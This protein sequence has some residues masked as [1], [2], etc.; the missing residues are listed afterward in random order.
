MS[1]LSGLSDQ[2]LLALAQNQG[3][4]VPPQPVQV[5]AL[6]PL[7]G[8]KVNSGYDSGF[9]L[10]HLS[11]EQLQG[12][13]ANANPQMSAGEDIGRSVV[14]GFEKA[15][16]GALGAVGNLENLW[17]QGV[18]WAGH[19]AISGLQNFTGSTLGAPDMRN[20]Q[21][22]PG[23][24]DYAHFNGHPT[25]ADYDAALQSKLG[26]YHAPQT[27]AAR[28]AER[29]AEFAPGAAMGGGGLLARGA[30][31]VAPAIASQG[32][33][34]LAPDK[35]KPAAALVGALLGGGAVGAGQRLAQAPEASFASAAGNLTDAQ[36]QQA[37]ALR[38][39][40]ATRGLNLTVPE[41]IQ[42]VTNNA[43]G[44]G[45]LQRVVESTKQGQTLTAPYFADRANQVSNATR[46][47]ADA[48]APATDQ[49]S[50]VGQRA[51]EAAST[52]LNRARQ[53]VN[54]VAQPDYAALPTQQMDPAAYATL[55]ADPSYRIALDQ[56]RNHPELGATVAG[57]P[58]NSL[59]VINEVKKRLAVGADQA[60]GTPLAPGDNHL[61]A[62]R[63]QSRS[64]ADAAA[65]AASNEYANANDTVAQLSGQYVEPLRSGPL[66]AISNTP[67]VKAQT[68]ALYPGI[69]V[70][71]A[72]AETAAAVRVLSNT[73]PGVAEDLTR[74]HIVN[75]LNESLSQ[76]QGGQNQY[77]GAKLAVALAGNPEQAATLNAGLSALP[78]GAQ[79][80]SE[81]DSLLEALRATGKR[82][83][84]GSMTAFNES[85]LKDLHI[86]PYA[87]A[88]GRI[89][90]PLEWGK[91][92]GDVLNRANYRRNV[93]RLAD[94]IMS[95][96]EDTAATLRGDQLRG[97][98]S[99]PLVAA[100][101]LSGPGTAR[102]P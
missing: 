4:L 81:M 102:Q 23:T 73:A 66:G 10:S 84:P 69:P 5:Q 55:S 88:V 26:P 13:A 97:G 29:I 76:L 98:T 17:G 70:E 19:K 41:A 22:D 83:Q 52:S 20:G 28:Y 37:Q 27:D 2:Q 62:L 12:L 58:D 85:D 31:V 53:V 63:T 33:E 39:S 50:M 49:P 92:I 60:A 45:R 80:A 11:P 9:D 6:P 8:A 99:N 93:N 95:A 44:L 21:N 91:G 47:L 96:P 56:L 15:G 94:I 42:Q 67:A 86:A 77:A 3:G 79:H 101:L 68:A 16:T 61:A 48:I 54:S 7:P 30:T 14:T 57:L 32:A 90:D 18:D 40:A 74:Q 43:T 78:G 82:Q 75:H 36:I 25:G 89:A 38:L 51:Q 87:Q 72:P 59:A 34:D 46:A 24:M 71:G 100:L 35:Y 65:R 64:T 1:D